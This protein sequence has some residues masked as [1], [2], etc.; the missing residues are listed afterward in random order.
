MLWVV[1]LYPL[2]SI[3]LPHIIGES[4]P[5][6]GLK[7]EVSQPPSQQLVPLAQQPVPL[8]QPLPVAQQLLA[9]QVRVTT[10]VTLLLAPVQMMRSLLYHAC[11]CH[12]LQCLLVLHCSRH[13]CTELLNEYNWDNLQFLSWQVMEIYL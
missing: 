10:L 4:K 2:T 7:S 8:A 13:T 12:C 1:T 6:G 11:L 5:V 9:Q 3:H